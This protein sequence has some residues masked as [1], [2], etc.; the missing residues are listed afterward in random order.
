MPLVAM[1]PLIDHAHAHRYAVGAYQV[2]DSTFVR[3]VLDAAEAEQAPVI[4]GFAEAHGAHYDF[5][6]LLAAACSAAHAA[7]VPVALLYDHASDPTPIA[8]AMRLGCQGV[9]ADYSG[10]PFADNVAATR[11]V[12]DLAH[13]KQVMVEGE[14]GYVPGTSG[15]ERLVQR[16]SM[17][18]T[19]PAEAAEFVA[20]TGVDCLAVAVGTVHGHLV[21]EP[22]LDLARLEAIAAAVPVPLVIHGGSGLAD[23]EYRG[24]IERGVAKINYFTALSDV[25]AA[26]SSDALA[27]IEAGYLRAVDAVRLAVAA[28]V[29]RT[30][31]LFRAS[32][33]A[34]HARAAV[35]PA[36]T[37]SA[38]AVHVALQPEFQ[39]REVPQLAALDARQ[40]LSGFGQQPFDIA[41]LVEAALAAGLR[42]EDAAHEFEKLAA[43]ELERGHR[44]VAL[45]PVD[46]RGGQQL[47]RDGLEDVLAART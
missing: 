32:G 34:R 40:M 16:S 23:E 14:L 30:L 7:R 43:H 28:E 5:P 11:A 19:A 15:A 6:A 31:R 27:D 24:L 22:Q 21:G 33:Q 9:M 35:P 10:K 12:V 39:Q 17:R 45:G 44:K 2:V 4:L 1:K 20:A 3:A 29:A 26:A 42:I 37:L 8:T 47:A 36:P 38:H 25:A 41:A 46:D 18:L 13:G